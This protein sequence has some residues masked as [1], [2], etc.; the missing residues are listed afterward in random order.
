MIT[1]G[2]FF[3]AIMYT[4]Y[5]IYIYTVYLHGTFW[6]DLLLNTEPRFQGTTVN[7]KSCFIWSV[8]TKT[9]SDRGTASLTA[10]AI[11]EVRFRTNKSSWPKSTEHRQ[12]TDNLAQTGL[13][14]SDLLT[15]VPRHRLHCTDVLLKK[16]EARGS[17]A[18]QEQTEAH[19]LRREICVWVLWVKWINC[20]VK[21]CVST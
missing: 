6:A 18:V 9:Q 3:W 21:K 14:R 17:V 5:Y 12:C 13:D 7:P 1:L 16:E 20:R 10:A 15:H 8:Q 4:T 11:P 19:W 2:I